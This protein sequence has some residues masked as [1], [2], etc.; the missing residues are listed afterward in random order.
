MLQKKGDIWMAR[1]SNSKK[2]CFFFKAFGLKKFKNMMI[3]GID[4]I[5]SQYNTH[6]VKTGIY[7]R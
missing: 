7:Q 1:I 3:V 5:C 6:M 4:Y 2:T